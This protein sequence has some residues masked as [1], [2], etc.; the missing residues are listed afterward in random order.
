MRE[1]ADKGGLP[2]PE[3]VAWVWCDVLKM[4]PP[5]GLQRPRMGSALGAAVLGHEKAA[6]TGPLRDGKRDRDSSPATSKRHKAAAELA[7]GHPADGMH[8]RRDRW[9]PGSVDSRSREG[10]MGSAGQRNG[11]ARA[12]LRGWQGGTA[13]RQPARGAARAPGARLDGGGFLQKRAYAGSDGFGL[14]PA[15]GPSAGVRLRAQKQLA[16]LTYE[17]YLQICGEIEEEFRRALWEQRMR[18]PNALSEWRAL[19]MQHKVPYQ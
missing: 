17:Q 8:A 2:P 6:H 4:Q 15:V 9:I 14:P 11:A 10:F 18:Q 5:Q 7:T 12:D 1:E 19:C 3:H 13:Q 16:G